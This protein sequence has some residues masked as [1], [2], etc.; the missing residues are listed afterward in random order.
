MGE[1]GLIFVCLILTFILGLRFFF[2]YHERISYSSGQNI[3]FETTLLSQPEI[4]SNRQRL[5][6]NLPNAEL[7]YIATSDSPSFDYG[8]N[9][10]VSGKLKKSLLKDGRSIWTMS[11]P[12][13]GVGKS[14]SVLQFIGSV[15]QKI[16][17]V[18]ERTLPPTSASLLLG[19]VFGIKEQMPKTFL[20]NLRQ[21]GVLHVIAASGMN[22]VMV[23]GFLTAVFSV[24]LKRQL[25]LIF[26]LFGILFYAVLAGLEPSIIRAA[27]M[28]SLVFLA[29]IWGK[30]SFPAY[31]LFLAGFSMLF[32]SPLT[33]SDVGFQLSF[34]ATLGLL[35]IRPIFERGKLATLIKKSVI[36]EDLTTTMAAQLATFPII[37]SNFGAYSLFSVIVNV[38]VLWTVP[39][40]MILGGVAA[41]LGLVIFPLG[42]LF[43]YLTLPF[44]F[45][46]ENIVSFFGK[47]GAVLNFQSLPWQITL[48]YYIL[49]LAMVLFFTRKNK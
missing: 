31:G 19:I 3:K 49:L 15:R 7:V 47:N 5:S 35:Y 10:E 14:S 6:A 8:D 29:Q 23:S 30:Q 11:F 26:S 39:P 34:A 36:G 25:A 45:Y 18:F 20:D 2:F 1:R 24:F 22:V 21:V 16:I 38:L 41:V 33:I 40:L 46:F 9:L 48:G 44:L 17:S 13:I 42:Q 37:I 28:G 43:L 4:I 32:V 12:K 27:I